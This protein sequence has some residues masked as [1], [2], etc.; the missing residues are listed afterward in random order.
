MIKNTLKK[1]KYTILNKYNRL[2]LQFS[3]IIWGKNAITNKIVIDNFLGKGYGGDVKYIID[4]L[5][6]RNSGIDIVLLAND[7]HQIIPN[8]I[9]L[10]K[11]G[12][13]KSLKEFHTAK[14]WISNV[15]NTYKPNRKEGQYYLQI[16]HGSHPVKLIEK[17]CVQNLSKEYIRQAK[18]DGRDITH[19]LVDCKSQEELYK[20]YFWLN[21]NVEFLKF[22]YLRNDYLVT[23]KND[24]EIKNRLKKYFS[25]KEGV[26]ILLYAPTFRDDFNVKGY[27]SS[28]DKFVKD[29]E[30]AGI[31]AV[32]LVRLHPNDK[33]NEYFYRYSD[34]IINA[35]HYVNGQDLVLLSD[36]IITDYSTIA[37]DGAIIKKP[38]FILEKDLEEYKNTRG[39]SEAYY[40]WPFIKTANE[41]KLT[42]AIIH[43]DRQDYLNRLTAYY[44]TDISYDKGNTA[45]QTAN[46]LMKVMLDDNS[47]AN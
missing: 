23:H 37:F 29:L 42:E 33:T 19:F 12:S 43:F 40:Q 41:H 9:R 14:I 25:I 11:Y 46:W 38:V 20:R 30:D 6:S 47:I 3:N 35:N 18:I 34:R 24:D 10:V 1:I 16:W 27:I 15:R 21:R 26:Q 28:L 32:V 39:L 8:G 44:T 7:L 5:L 45:K 2:M 22:G 36:A 17:Q 31:M 13:F 4:E